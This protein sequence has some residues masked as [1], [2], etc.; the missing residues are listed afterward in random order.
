MPNEAAAVAKAA[1]DSGVARKKVKPQDVA[2]NTRVL[3][4]EAR[5]TFEALNK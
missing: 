1:M 2:E 5:R 4:E 3:A